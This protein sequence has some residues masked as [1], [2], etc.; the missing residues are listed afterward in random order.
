M[1]FWR[2]VATGW[3]AAWAIII[4]LLITTHLSL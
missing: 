3:A 1:D 4:I 2:G